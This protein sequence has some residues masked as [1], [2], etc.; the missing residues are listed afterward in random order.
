MASENWTNKYLE[1]SD[2][3][4]GASDYATYRQSFISLL[5]KLYPENFND[6]I[7]NSE[8]IMMMSAL[9]YLGENL[10]YVVEMNTRDNFPATTERLESLLN[11]AR[12]INYPVKRNVCA[13]GLAKIVQIQTD[14]DLYD[15][16][17]T[18]LKDYPIK[19]NDIS[20][21]YW[22]EQMM[23][24][25]NSVFINSNPFGIPVDSKVVSDETY[26][27]YSLNVTSQ[28]G[29]SYAFNAVVNGMSTNFEVV[30]PT[31]ENNNLIEHYP[32]ASNFF[33][34]IYKNDG[35]GYDSKNNGFFV[36]FKQGSLGK[37]DQA[38][39]TKESFKTIEVGAQGIN[40]SDVWVEEL[41]L[42]GSIKNVWKQVDDF[43]NVSYSD[44]DSS[45]KNIYQVITNSNDD[46]TIKFG[47]GL[48]GNIPFGNFRIFYRTSNGMT[49]SINPKEMSNIVITIPYKDSSYQSDQI[50]HLTVTFSLQDVVNNSIPSL[51]VADIQDNLPQ[52]S[53][54]QNRMVTEQ[55]YNYY[56]LYFTNILKRVIAENRVYSGVIDNMIDDNQSNIVQNVNII[57]DDGYVYKEYQTLSE[58]I[59]LPTLMG[60]QAI[61]NSYI[62]PLLS[63][64]NLVN[65]F[66]DKFPTINYTPLST[67]EYKWVSSSVSEYKTTDT[68][69]YG[70][71]SD[72]GI[73]P[74]GIGIGSMLKFVI[75]EDEKVVKEQWVTIT[76]IVGLT[77]TRTYDYIVIDKKLEYDIWTIKLPDNTARIYYPFNESISTS[78][79]QE[80]LNT[81]NM[82]ST[83]NI[84]GVSEP[85][86]G[87]RY[88]TSDCAWHLIEGSA[89]GDGEFDLTSAGLGYDDD[90]W[91]VR[92]EWTPTAWLIKW[93]SVKYLFGSTET[94]RFPNIMT[95]NIVNERSGEVE[96][97]FIKFL[98]INEN[99]NTNSH[100]LEDIEMQIS[101]NEY[102]DD[103]SLN[104]Y[105][106]GVETYSAL[107]VDMP[108]NPEIMNDLI[109]HIPNN[110]T[111]EDNKF[112]FF[113]RME[114]T[115]GYYEYK[116]TNS[117]LVIDDITNITPGETLVPGVYYVINGMY[118]GNFVNVDI[119]GNQT[120][121]TDEY[122]M[123][124]GRTGLFAQYKHFATDY[125]KIDPVPS[126]FI[127]MYVLTNNF[128]KAVM[129]WKAD[130]NRSLAT[131]PT[132]PT[133]YELMKQFETLEENK[134]LTDELIWRPLK[135]K[136]LFGKEADE[137]LRAD[138]KITKKNT[139]LVADNILRQRVL[140]YM[141]EFFNS[142]RWL[143]TKEFNYTELASYI[144]QNMSND[145]TNCVIVPLYEPYRFGKLYQIRFSEYE[146]PLNVATLDSIKIIPYISDENIRIGK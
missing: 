116:Y 110:P 118:G 80:I 53:S 104:P 98:K 139:S 31:I 128:Y 101:S 33:N 142:T 79:S 56:P 21:T 135:F 74:E 69:D 57:V 28:M 93:R 66:Y 47:D 127:E 99:P 35:T 8:V 22:Y 138:I 41:N 141:E 111:P 20:N 117:V 24:V 49:Y 55:D 108:A 54:T 39:N 68:Y 25:L 42:D 107:S 84:S 145:I 129:D 2:I 17:G 144:Y 71:I 6:Y 76:N 105:I 92:V 30:N 62:L 37:K 73:L 14:E 13:S 106:V 11:F 75:I 67:G 12:M 136:L 60:N 89:I 109:G 83:L 82:I 115:N 100:Y 40:D 120:V 122:K 36:W 125:I 65:F 132:Y 114:S 44:I 19:W 88:D 34:I 102:N 43:H 18:S 23:V 119:N 130:S 124:Y 131:F 146:I 87:L 112:L 78:L 29:V 63:N 61:I 140:M 59:P 7:D 126:A 58:L 134:M 38:I 45:E 137:K 4:Y 113:K 96:H 86:F 123:F 50:F 48:T 9:A 46:I 97:D 133:E 94:I 143:N 32:D 85:K 52:V 51:T 72:L 81:M 64:K 95:T 27:L 26:N 16:M 103:G 77:N 5:Q 91:L 10:N 3:N 90:S 121:L 1:N 15:A 70:K